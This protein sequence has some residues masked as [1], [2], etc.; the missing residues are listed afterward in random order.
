MAIDPQRAARKEDRDDRNACCFQALH[1]VKAAACVVEIKIGAVA[2][3]FGIGVFAEYDD[4][5]VGLGRKA[6]LDRELGLAASRGQDVADAREDRSGAGEMLRLGPGPLPGQRPAARLFGDIVGAVAGDEDAALD[7]ERQDAVIFEQHQRFPHRLP[8]YRAMVG[9]AEQVVA[10]RMFACRW[11]AR[12]EQSGAQLHAEDAAHRIV[13]PRH[14]QRP[15]PRGGERRGVEPFPARGSH[16]YV[17]S[18][19]NRRGAVGWRASRHLRMAIPVADDEPVEAP[20]PLEHAGQQTRVAVHL[21]AI[22]SREA[23][24]H[25]LDVGLERGDIGGGMKADQFGL[26]DSG[27]AAIAAFRRA[28]IGEEMLRRG[29]DM[30]PLQPIRVAASPLDAVDECGSIACRDRRVLAEAFI[31]PPPAVIARDRDRWRKGPVEPGDAHLDCGDLPD[32]FDQRGVP[33]RA[34]ADIVREQRRADDIVMTVDRVRSPHHRDARQVAVRAHRRI[35]IGV[36]RRD[37]RRC[38]AEFIAAGRRTAAVE[39]R[40]QMISRDVIGGR[41]A[42]IALDDLADLLFE[43]HRRDQ[44]VDSLLDRG[45]GGASGQNGP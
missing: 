33:R 1:R 44:R 20:A 29:D 11:L 10:A 41:A 26:G 24:H 43:R 34:E 31:S 25:A 22:P 9:R 6:A 28:A 45:L 4:R 3:E 18:G 39:D 17:E 7:L 42:D 27:V 5:R 8:R 15:R 16:K 38:R 40:A 13:E 35:I 21:D 19:R 32:P 30:R 14:R 37:P 2:L 23:R 12:L 36:G